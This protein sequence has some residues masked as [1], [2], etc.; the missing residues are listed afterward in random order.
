MSEWK[1]TAQHSC[2]APRPEVGRGGREK[3]LLHNNN[4]LERQFKRNLIFT[5]LTKVVIESIGIQ[6]SRSYTQTHSEPQSN[7]N[8]PLMAPISKNVI[9]L[10]IKIIFWS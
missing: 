8:I 9:A 10:Q 3:G 5:I 1:E 7:R 4:V 2:L 6:M